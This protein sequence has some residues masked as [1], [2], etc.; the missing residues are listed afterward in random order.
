MAVA[1]RREVSDRLV[2]KRTT[3]DDRTALYGVAGE[4][5]PVLFLHGWALGQ[6]SY[7]QAMKRLIQ[8]GCRV[9]APALPGFGGT[10]DLPTRKLSIPGYADWVGEFCEAVKIDEPVFL[11]GHSFGGGVSIRFA[12]DHPDRVRSA[13]LVNAVGG[14]AWAD[15]KDRVRPMQE[16]P[17]WD[18]GIRIPA[19]LLPLPNWRRALPMVLEDTIPNLIRNPGAIWRVAQLARRADLREELEQLKARQLPVVVL[20][21]EEDRVIPRASF[22]AL[23]RAVGQPGHVVAGN[24]SWLLADPD[25][26]GEV[27]TNVV[28]VAT[29]ARAQ[30]AEEASRAGRPAPAVRTLPALDAE[31]TAVD[32]QGADTVVSG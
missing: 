3:V 9:Y 24:H 18:W 5:L 27:L 25:A 23:C 7:K 17:L 15:R 2:W 8:L 12:H 26:F 29:L 32:A 14:G 19:D 22:D 11:V 20:W 1:T 30:E 28:Q 6:H 4:G 31:A 10:P 21:S 13:V 16:R